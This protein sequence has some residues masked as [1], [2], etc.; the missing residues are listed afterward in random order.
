MSESRKQTAG[1]RHGLSGWHH[2]P[3]ATRNS[4]KG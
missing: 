2:G 1:W 3:S 4:R